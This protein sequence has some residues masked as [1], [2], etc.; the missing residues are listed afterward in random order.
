MF[1]IFVDFFIKELTVVNTRILKP[2][3]LLTT[4]FDDIVI[5]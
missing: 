2:G 1:T 4:N 5:K 3:Y